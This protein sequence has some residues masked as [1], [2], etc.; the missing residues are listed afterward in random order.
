ML[1]MRNKTSFVLVFTLMTLHSCKGWIEVGDDS[2]LLRNTAHYEIACYVADGINSG[3]SY[4]DTLLP[5]TLN[6]FVFRES[7][8]DSAWVFGT[9]GG[10]ESFL[11]TAT[12]NGV[13]SLFIFKQVDVERLGWEEVS[14]KNQYIVRYDLTSDNL[15]FLKGII[16]YPPNEPMKDIH[17]FPSYEQLLNEL[18]NDENSD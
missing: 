3:F 12:Q 16:V 6:S 13:L 14:S 18:E 8:K 10:F 7:I 5:S 17:M 4:P 2:I 11:S 9:S 1:I 15:R